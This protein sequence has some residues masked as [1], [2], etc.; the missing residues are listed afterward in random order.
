L[1]NSI[2]N[3]STFFVTI[4]RKNCKEVKKDLTRFLNKKVKITF[5]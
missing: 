2:I 4:Q 5:R 3:S 1:A